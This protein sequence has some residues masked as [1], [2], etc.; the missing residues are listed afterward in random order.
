MQIRLK[1]GVLSLQGAV[2]EHLNMIK[3]CGFEGIKV[4]TL[5]DLEEVE[6]LIIPGGESITLLYFNSFKKVL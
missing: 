2:E 3:K 5:G 1:V 4:K 6:K